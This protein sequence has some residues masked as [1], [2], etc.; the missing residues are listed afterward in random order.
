MGAKVVMTLRVDEETR[1]V[2]TLLSQKSRHT[3]AGYLE[4]L[5]DREAEIHKIDR[6]QLLSMAAKTEGAGRSQEEPADETE[7]VL[8]LYLAPWVD[9]D[10]WR[11]FVMMRK[12]SKKKGMRPLTERAAI[13]ILLKLEKAHELGW[14]SDQLMEDAIT[15]EWMQ[16]VYE[17]HLTQAP[18]LSAVATT[19]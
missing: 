14:D 2:M 19:R 4:F 3:L 17:K 16:M 7:A 9:K 15:N 13:A 18:R 6:T 1:Q 11:D 12:N 10:L 8:N 5:M